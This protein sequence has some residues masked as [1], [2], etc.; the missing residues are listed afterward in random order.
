MPYDDR[1]MPHLLMVFI[2]LIL[3][4]ALAQFMAPKG[5]VFKDIGREHGQGAYVVSR[6]A[7]GFGA[8]TSVILVVMIASGTM[9]AFA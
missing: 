6:M 2:P 5:V 3:C 7:Y 1:F 9:Q 8:L 4:M